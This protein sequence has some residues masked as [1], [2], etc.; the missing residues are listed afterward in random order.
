VT[1][2]LAD[3]ELEN[4]DEGRGVVFLREPPRREEEGVAFRLLAELKGGDRAGDQPALLGLQDIRQPGRNAA[5]MLRMVFK[6]IEPD[7]EFAEHVGTLTLVT[8]RTG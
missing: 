2:L 8:L 6:M 7:F 4:A 3:E 1:L 5:G